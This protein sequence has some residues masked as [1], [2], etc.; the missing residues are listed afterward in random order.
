M[1]IYVCFCLTQF[2]EQSPFDSHNIILSVRPFVLPKDYWSGIFDVHQAIK[3]A[4][5][6]NGIKMAYSE[7]VEL[8][9]I[10]G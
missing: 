8:G 10:G 3:A 5:N 4:F 6:R 2:H 1:Q 7:G 9:P